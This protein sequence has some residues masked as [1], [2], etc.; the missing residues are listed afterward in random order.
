MS[1]LSISFL[2]YLLVV[3]ADRAGMKAMRAYAEA[4]K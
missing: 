4:Q 3:I 2:L 1:I